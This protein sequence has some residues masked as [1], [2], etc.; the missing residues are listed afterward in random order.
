MRTHPLVIL[1]GV[2]QDN[3]FFA[4]PDQYQAGSSDSG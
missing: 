3:L 4:P 1:A 2:L